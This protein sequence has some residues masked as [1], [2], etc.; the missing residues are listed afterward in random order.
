MT[1]SQVNSMATILFPFWSIT[2]HPRTTT[3]ACLPL[4][5]WPWTTYVEVHSRF[6]Q[7]PT[8]FYCL[9]ESTTL[10]PSDVSS[11]LLALSPIH[12]HLLT[13]TRSDLRN[14]RWRWIKLQVLDNTHKKT[15]YKGDPEGI[16]IEWGCRSL[17]IQV[18]DCNI[19]FPLEKMEIPG[20]SFICQ[21]V[22]WKA[23]SILDYSAAVQRLHLRLKDF[24]ISEPRF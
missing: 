5:R 2:I 6:Q 24:S 20:D 21:Y 22:E 10:W 16:Q 23:K 12:Q 9:P 14:S 15:G 18:I 11:Q 1:Q 17:L 4:C 7:S 8:T 13:L 19:P 3:T